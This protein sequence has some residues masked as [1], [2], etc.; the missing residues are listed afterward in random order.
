MWRALLTFDL[1]SSSVPLVTMLPKY[2]KSY[3]S[4]SSSP[5]TSTTLLLWAFILHF[6][7]P[8]VNVQVY[9][10]CCLMKFCCFV[11]DMSMCG[12]YEAKVVSIVQTIKFIIQ[13]PPDVIS[14]FCCC[15]SLMIQFIATDNTKGYN[16]R[17]CFSP[18]VTAIQT[19]LPDQA[20]TLHWEPS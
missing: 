17:P 10:S 18:D 20:I 14:L 1:M 6:S 7:F 9:T 13:P 11:L 2:V 19:I 8:N 5:F 15:V 16:I 3:T 12:R 4:S